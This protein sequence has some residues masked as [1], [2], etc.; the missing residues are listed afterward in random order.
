[1]GNLRDHM[2]PQPHIRNGELG[3]QTKLLFSDV[4]SYFSNV[5]TKLQQA[6]NKIQ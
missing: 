4:K 2:D 3:G 6:Y 5:G 1:M